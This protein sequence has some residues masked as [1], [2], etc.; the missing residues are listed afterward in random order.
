MS[1][2]E[3]TVA[4]LVL[5]PVTLLLCSCGG[6][7]SSSSSGSGPP[8]TPLSITTSALPSGQ[9]GVQYTATLTATGGTPPLSWSSGSLPSGLSLEAT[10]G[11]ISGMPAA[12]SDTSISFQVADSGSPPKANQSVWP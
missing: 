3:G 7:G 10:T 8:P 5:L 2:V 4:S 12:T 6:G 1:K 9:T 11:M